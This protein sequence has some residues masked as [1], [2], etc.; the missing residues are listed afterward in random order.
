MMI[1]LSGMFF[2]MFIFFC[3][4]FLKMYKNMLMILLFMELMVLSL[5]IIMLENLMMMELSNYLLIYYL[6]FSV[7]ESV[8]GLVIII[9][10]I[11]IKGN[12]LV[13]SLSLMKW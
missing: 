3:L 5:F 1:T 11:R 4:G 2:F 8:L 9:M 7:C 13:H 6:I 10:L 12:D